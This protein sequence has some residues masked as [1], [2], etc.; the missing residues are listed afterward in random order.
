MHDHE[1]KI[2][3]KVL[4]ELVTHMIG[5]HGSKSHSSA[6]PHVDGTGK[7]DHDPLGAGAMSHHSPMADAM[8]E[9]AEPEVAEAETD[10]DD[11]FGRKSGKKMAF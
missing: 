8:S 2:R 9:H 6:L 1:G 11:I 4:G 7:H 3:A 10:P 5:Q